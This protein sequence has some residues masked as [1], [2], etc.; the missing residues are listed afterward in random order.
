MRI[1]INKY[2]LSAIFVAVAMIVT[3]IVSRSPSS[4]YV[5]QAHAPVR[6]EPVRL[7]LDPFVEEFKEF[8]VW[9]VRRD[10]KVLGHP[11]SAVYIN[12]DKLTDVGL[13]RL[14]D[15]ATITAFEFETGHVSNEGMQFLSKLTRLTHL[16]VMGHSVSD[17]GFKV[18]GQLR[19]L[20]R[21]TV[22]KSS[23]GDVALAELNG[24]PV[25]RFLD[26]ASTAV[27]DLGFKRLKNLPELKQLI[28]RDTSFGELTSQIGDFGLGRLACFPKLEFLQLGHSKTH[29]ESLIGIEFCQSLKFI[30]LEYEEISDQGVEYISRS[31]SLEFLQLDSSRISDVSI[32][33][34]LKM[35]QLKRLTIL[36]SSITRVGI[37]AIGGKNGL[38]A[39]VI[40]SSAVGDDEIER[41]LHQIS[42]S[43]TTSLP[44]D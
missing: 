11:V 28:L 34:L 17:G 12:N 16:G 22:S 38:V 13:G 24:L 31:R 20:E 30:D 44:T 15:V 9:A 6:E 33:H 8:G 1:W 26:L 2:A 42:P 37:Q 14:T 3:W 43:M 18:I 36:S 23:F 21:L 4:R 27:T 32:S 19:D 10:L 40:R 7:P 5:K 35:P 39:C 41:I 29:D 25:L